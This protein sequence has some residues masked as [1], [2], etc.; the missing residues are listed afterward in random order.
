MAVMKINQ[1]VLKWRDMAER[2]SMQGV[3]PVPPALILAIIQ[4]ESAGNPTAKRAE[5]E[6]LACA[7]RE[8]RD[9]KIKVIADDEYKLKSVI[10]IFQ[11]K[12]V[13]RGLSLKSFDYGKV[14]SAFQGTVRQVITVKKGINK[15]KAKE[16][17]SALKESKLK[18]QSQIM[19]D[20]LRMS[21]KD[22]DELQKVIALLKQRDFG[23]DLQFVNY[24]S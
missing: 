22:K 12:A 23:I 2:W 17:V 20:Q 1:K 21:S 24:R 5:P 10:D 3:Y 8:R 13:K 14:E 18:V 7:V 15:D 4:M 16:I 9:D 19:D 11:T 6:A